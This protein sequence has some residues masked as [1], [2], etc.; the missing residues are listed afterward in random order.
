MPRLDP[1]P[2]QGIAGRLI[3]ASRALAGAVDSMRFAAPTACVYNPLTYAH[4]PYEEYLRRFASTPKRVVFLGMNPGP[5]GMAQ[6]GVPFGEVEM[7]RGWMGIEQPVGSPPRLHPKRPI[8]GFAC[9]KSEVSG[10]RLWGLMRERF[11]TADFFFA[12]HFVANYCPLVF[13]EESGRNR[14]PDRLPPSESGAL[15]RECD[16]HLREV[17]LALEPRWLIGIGKFAAERARG[18]A[19]GLAGEGAGSSPTVAAILH[20]SPANPQANR[21]WEQQVT[22][23][24]RSLEV[25]E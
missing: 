5:W 3:I 9:R 18:V 15:F 17:I 6:T 20:P 13:M 23:Q 19:A 24:L 16:R 25:W 2:A 1:S 4:A 12:D 7:V 21:G 8:E 22:A 14:T 11:G 10:R